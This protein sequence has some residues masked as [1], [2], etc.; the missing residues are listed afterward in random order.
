MNYN[1]VINDIKTLS[2]IAKEHK[3]FADK[4]LEDNK[5]VLQDE[6]GAEMF[7][8][9]MDANSGKMNLE[10]LKDLI[11]EIKNAGKSNNNRP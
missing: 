5:Q 8:K 10:D 2:K 6:L 11:K 4:V 7:K 3:S 1:K 9:I